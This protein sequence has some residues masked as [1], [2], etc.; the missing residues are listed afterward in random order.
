MGEAVK[1]AWASEIPEGAFI[2]DSPTYEVGKYFS[3]FSKDIYKSVDENIKQIKYYFF[4]PTEHGYNSDGKYPL[5]VF[6]HGSGNSLVGDVCINYTG[7]EFFASEQYQ[8]ALGGAYLLIPIANEYRDEEK[9][10]TCGGWGPEY[11]AV[12]YGLIESFIS[13]NAGRIGKKF[14]VG[15][16]S[17]ARFTFELGNVY[18]GFFNGLIPIGTGAVPS[19]E[20]LDEY[21]R[22]GVNLFF[23][24]GKHDE[25]NPFKEE[26]EPRISKLKS[27]KHCFCFTPEW[28]YNGDGGIAS[29]DVGIEMGQHCLINAMHVNL[30][31]DDGRPMYDY[32]P[33]G[34]IGWMNG[35]ISGK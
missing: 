32:L 31:F 26:I 29:I 11:D 12:I 7:A 22:K 3:L 15:N 19:D 23:A 8:K 17:G 16:S 20:K 28:V 34:I 2:S 9:K 33:E 4:D 13:R 14:L 35:V 25:F 6:L 30:M 24:I 21:E 18:T 27:M 10:K 5:I 1:P